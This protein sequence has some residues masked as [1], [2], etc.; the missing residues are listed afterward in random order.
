MAAPHPSSGPGAADT[1]RVHSTRR[2]QAGRG[3]HTLRLQIFTECLLG[4]GHQGTVVI[5]ADNQPRPCEVISLGE[6]G[7]KLQSINSMMI[8]TQKNRL[9]VG[10]VRG[11]D[12]GG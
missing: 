4:A 2:R 10:W 11:R 7:N 12:R 6:T 5:K 1:V 8:L 9:G 3:T